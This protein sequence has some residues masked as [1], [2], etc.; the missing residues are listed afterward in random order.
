MQLQLRTLRSNAG[1][2]QTELA[3]RIGTTLRRVSA[4]E[5]GEIQITLEDACRVADFYH[6]TLDELAGRW[7]YVGT[8]AADPDEVEIVNAY[9]DTDSRG[10]ENILDTARREKRAT[11]PSE[12]NPLQ[13][14][15]IS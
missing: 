14:P 11:R 9:R 2:S 15:S 13:Q 8:P 3:K 12:D 10:K 4:W 6:I 1:M 7:E 5:R